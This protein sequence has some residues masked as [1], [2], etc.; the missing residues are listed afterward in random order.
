MNIDQEFNKWLEK[1]N[2]SEW[3]S[4]TEIDSGIYVNLKQNSEIYT[5]Y[6]GQHIW[7]SIFRENCFSDKLHLMCVEER[8][9][10]KIFSGLLSNINIQI[11][12]NYYDQINNSTQINIKMFNERFANHP[13]RV[14]NLF[15]L[16][17]LLVKAFQR[18][19]NIIRNYDMNT[20]NEFEDL[21]SSRIIEMIYDSNEMKQLSII[22]NEN[23]YYLNKFLNFNKIDQL[24]RKFRN[25]SSIVD[26]VSCQKC[27]L[28]GKLQIYG[29]ATMLKILSDKTYSGKEN[30]NT[31]LSRNE[32]ISFVNLFGKVSNS[33][34]HI[35]KINDYIVYNHNLYYSKILVI[36]CI[37]LFA[38]IY[39]N[40][41]LLVEKDNLSKVKIL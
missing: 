38:F 33:I 22:C 30:F 2:C 14:E 25:I 21:N 6:Q 34:N 29:L 8:V 19:E 10:Y 16:F 27:K 37:Y 35:K 31:N 18:L 40:F 39:L 1:Y 9:F 32:L 12:T 24:V 3:I 15:F 4:S 26:C 5:G 13:D 23:S 41:I 28:H 7:D 17:S 11:S 36:I 20:G